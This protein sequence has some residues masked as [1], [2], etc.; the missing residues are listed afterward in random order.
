MT[1][2]GMVRVT[3]QS[4]ARMKWPAMIIALALLSFLLSALG[5]DDVVSVHRAHAAAQVPT[6]SDIPPPLR[7]LRVAQ[8]GEGEPRRIVQHGRVISVPT[9]CLSVNG[10]YDLVLHFHG[11]P[12]ALEAAVVRS[13]LD[14][15]LAIV[16]LGIGSGVYDQAFA[17]PGSFPVFVTDVSRNLRKLCPQAREPKRIALSAWSAGYGAVWRILERSGQAE[18][19]DAVLLADGLHTGLVGPQ[20]QRNLDPI[21]LEPFAMFAELAKNG[22]RLLAITHT[23]IST[24]EYGSTTETAE[25]L[26]ER[27]GIEPKPENVPGPRPDMRLTSKADYGAFHILGFSGNDK[28][29]HADQLHAFGDTL[30]PYLRERWHK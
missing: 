5:R 15:A 29:A 25:Y 2:V 11:A 20:Q 4:R 17:A 19:V 8:P 22:E 24:L 13:G 9:G 6:R 28:Q 1:G 12:E 27:A 10:S 14:S 23:A 18:R 26:L 3:W 30:L 7:T 21:K 16:N